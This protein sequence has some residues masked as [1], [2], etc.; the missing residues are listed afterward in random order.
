MHF[1][2][3]KE[4]VQLGQTVEEEK[5]IDCDIPPKKIGFYFICSGK[6]LEILEHENQLICFLGQ[7]CWW[8]CGA[9]VAVG[10]RGC[11]TISILSC[12]CPE[13]EAV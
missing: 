8:Q 6:S 13:N 5:R 3:R 4:S 7:Q 10:E 2:S 9:R 11:Q 1:S 12:N